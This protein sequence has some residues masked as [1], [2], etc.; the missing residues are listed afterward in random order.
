MKVGDQLYVRMD[1]KVE[2]KKMPE[3]TFNAHL[4]Y[5]KDVAKERCFLGGGF[6]EEPGGM[7]IFVARTKEEAKSIVEGDP[8]IAEGFYTYELHLWELAITDDYLNG[9]GTSAH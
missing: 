1:R 7:I 3:E 6:K 8:I 2:G 4:I 5:L 9:G